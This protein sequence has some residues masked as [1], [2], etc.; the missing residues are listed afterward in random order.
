MTRAPPDHRPDHLRRGRPRRPRPADRPGRRGA[1]LGGADRH[2]PRRAR[3]R[4][5]L[6]ERRRRGQTRRRRPGRGRPRRWSPRPGPGRRWCGWS[7]ATRSPPTR[8]SRRCRP[9]PTPAC[10]STSCPAAARRPASPATR[11][12]RS[13]RRTPSPT[14]GVH[15]DWAGA[16]RAPGTLLLQAAPAHLAETAAALLAH[17]RSPAR[18][19]VL[20]HR[21]RHRR[22]RSAPSTARAG[23]ASTAI[24]RELTGPLVVTVGAGVAQRGRLSWWE[25]RA[26]YGWRCWSRRPRTRP[27]R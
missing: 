25:S 24:G 3:R 27:A 1:A 7:P 12:S 15:L 19:P 8:W 22:R 14:S 21:R 2:R 10:R 26:L 4:A 20:G 5:R 13:D 6:A 16:G 17:G 11:A 23:H 18:R 9:S